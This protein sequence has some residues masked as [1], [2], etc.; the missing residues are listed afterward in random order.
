MDINHIVDFLEMWK[1]DVLAEMRRAKKQPPRSMTMLDW[2]REWAYKNKLIVQNAFITQLMHGYTWGF[3]GIGYS[4]TLVKPM[5]MSK[6]Y[7]EYDTL[8][9]KMFAGIMAN[10]PF[11]DMFQKPNNPMVYNLFYSGKALESIKGVDFEVESLEY[12]KFDYRKTLFSTYNWQPI[13]NPDVEGFGLNKKAIDY[14]IEKYV[15]DYIEEQN[16]AVLEPKN[17]IKD[18][19]IVPF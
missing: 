12:V 13:H 8:K 3:T 16:G 9:D 11:K 1:V 4:K 18:E 17:K 15:L 19:D 6:G 14:L 10:R 5:F 7:M 2:F